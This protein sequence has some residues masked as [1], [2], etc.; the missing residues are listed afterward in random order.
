MGRYMDNKGRMLALTK[1]MKSEVLC[2]GGFG[3]VTSKQEYDSLLQVLK[4]VYDKHESE[5][6]FFTYVAQQPLS[7]SQSR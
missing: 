6:R 4:E 7:A 2:A 3:I 5:I 1:A